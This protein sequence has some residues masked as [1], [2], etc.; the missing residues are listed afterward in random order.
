MTEFLETE[1]IIDKKHQKSY[2]KLDVTNPYNYDDIDEK[3]KKLS[4]L[5]ITVE[6]SQNSIYYNFKKQKTIS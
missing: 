1:A 4:K 5:K 3:V 6:K 2:F